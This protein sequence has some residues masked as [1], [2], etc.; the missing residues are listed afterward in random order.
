MRKKAKNEKW[1]LLCKP[2]NDLR[3]KEKEDHIWSRKSTFVQKRVE[4]LRVEKVRVLCEDQKSGVILPF[5][6]K[7]LKEGRRKKE[8]ARAKSSK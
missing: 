6:L 2:N 8:E 5:L 3:E 4:S 1:G 7:I